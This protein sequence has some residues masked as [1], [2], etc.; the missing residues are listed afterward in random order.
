ML[1]IAVADV[2][3]CPADDG[4]RR[5][6]LY[7]FDYT[8]GSTILI[9]TASIFCLASLCFAKSFLCRFCVRYGPRPCAHNHQCCESNMHFSL[10]L[11]W[12][13]LSIL[14]CFGHTLLLPIWWLHRVAHVLSVQVY[15]I[16]W[17]FSR[18]LTLYIRGSHSSPGMLQSLVHLHAI[19]LAW[20]WSEA[21]ALSTRLSLITADLTVLIAT[22]IKTYR[23]VKQ[24]SS[25]EI[26]VGISATL[27]R[28]GAYFMIVPHYYR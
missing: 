27:L 21:V 16:P 9:S 17:T 18:S 13:K 23:H 20:G 6:R 24:A 7:V 26:R 8:I 25:L 11:N 14:P 1:R 15:P 10:L 28:D 2:P 4:S 22:W 5:S 3:L 12:R 19:Q